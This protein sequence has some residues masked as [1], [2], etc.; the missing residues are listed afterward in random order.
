MGDD[1]PV[2]PPFA[3]VE[4]S[5]DLLGDVSSA[6]VKLVVTDAGKISCG[7]ISRSSYKENKMYLWKAF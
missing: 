3:T 5:D 4:F 7:I 6:D 2:M 1:V